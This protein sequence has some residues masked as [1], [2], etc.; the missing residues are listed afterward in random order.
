MKV[1]AFSGPKEFAGQIRAESLIHVGVGIEYRV[2]SGRC[3]HV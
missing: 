2:A 3:D 1:M